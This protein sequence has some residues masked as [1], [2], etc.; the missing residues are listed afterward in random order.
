M[1]D[2]IA[3]IP[4]E[5]L[6]NPAY[7]ADAARTRA[8]LRG[9]LWK[10]ERSQVFREL[11]DPSWEAFMA[12]DWRGALDL[13][14]NDRVAV[15]AEAKRHAVQGLE[16]RRVRVAEM[17]IGPYLQWELHALKLLADE[18]DGLSVLTADQVSALETSAPLPEVNVVG[19]RVL[20]HIQYEDDGTP[21]GA[22]RITDPAVIG[23]AASEI[24]ALYR[25]GEPLLDFFEREVAPLSAPSV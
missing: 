20:Y 16:I 24:E 2:R 21:C 9:A 4:G 10:L 17:P 15:R 19:D 13:L 8:D 23:A 22:R 12:G 3:D 6:N 5:A 1:L 11:K 18:G 25:R 7:L 14:E